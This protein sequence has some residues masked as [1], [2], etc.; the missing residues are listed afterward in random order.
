MNHSAMQPL[1]LADELLLIALDEK[2][3]RLLTSS[4]F[5]IESCLA[6]AVVIE[7][8]LRQLL[9][10]KNNGFVLV[11]QGNLNDPLMEKVLEFL[12]GA[13][14]KGGMN[15]WFDAVNAGIP[16]LR[17]MVADG[18]VAKQL[19]SKV[20]NRFL[21]IFTSDAYVNDRQQMNDVK[22]RL[23]THVLSGKTIDIRTYL[24]LQL[25]KFA[26]LFEEI[27]PTVEEFKRAKKLI[28]QLSFDSC[29]KGMQYPNYPALLDYIFTKS[30]PS[31]MILG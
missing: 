15:E 6:G 24:L 16:A 26:D 30:T 18:L 27:F 28:S 29:D 31:P 11:E 12:R 25:V 22:K 4:N 10:P 21:W 23:K 17:T 13:N 7:L 1:T 14:V 20:K 2:R 19:V 5:S 3:G 8:S 9:V